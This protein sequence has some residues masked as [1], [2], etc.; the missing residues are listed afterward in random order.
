MDSTTRLPYTHR[1]KDF[2]T[3][4]YLG[5]TRRLRRLALHAVAQH[6]IE[7]TAIRLLAHG[8]NT[9]YRV[10]GPAGTY[11]CRIHRLGY[12]TPVTIRSE[13]DWLHALQRDTD[14]IVPRPLLAPGAPVPVLSVPGLRPRPVVL[15]RWTHGR[16]ELK[17]TLPATLFKTGRFIAELHQ[18][19]ASWPTPP[20]FS[21]QRWDLAGLTGGNLGGSLAWIPPEHAGLAADAVGKIA[22]V[23]DR[24]G[25]DAMLLIHADFHGA[26]RLLTADGQLAAIDFDDCGLG[27]VSYDLAVT[28]SYLRANPDYAQLRAA[29]LAGYRQVRAFDAMQEAAISDFFA[30]RRLFIWL[31]VLSRTADNPL[32]RERAPG[33]TKRAVGLLRDYVANRESPPSATARVSIP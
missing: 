23:F 31:W 29:L 10:D 3:L 24:L 26:N 14:L 27:H 8:E 25:H 28:L 11:L 30:L 5:Q 9:T 18:H 6:A 21:R 20:G 22:A 4:T 7:S 19:T 1:V 15:F 32:F 2:E 13:L 12:Q 33:V 17:R 16:F